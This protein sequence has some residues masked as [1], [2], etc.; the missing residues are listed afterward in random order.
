MPRPPLSADLAATL[1]ERLHTAVLGD[2]DGVLVIPA[3][4]AE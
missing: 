1:R 3:G 4:G 2:E